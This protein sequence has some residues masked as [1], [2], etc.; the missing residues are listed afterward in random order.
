MKKTFIILFVILSTVVGFGIGNICSDIEAVKWLAIGGEIGFKE[1]VV[2]D[3]TFL[4][5]SLRIWCRVNVAGILCL[6]IS[7][8][9]ARKIFKWLK[10]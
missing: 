4:Q 6:I 5:F 9:F 2:L 3:L 10:I 1:P 8:F 7:A